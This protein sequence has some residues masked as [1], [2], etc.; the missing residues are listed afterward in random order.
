[1]KKFI[2]KNNPGF[3]FDKK[4]AQEYGERLESVKDIYGSLTADVVLQ[5]AEKDDSPYHNEFI[6]DDTEA[7]HRW[8]KHTARN[9]IGCIHV[10]IEDYEPI[11]RNFECVIVEDEKVYEDIET[12]I[13]SDDLREQVVD[14]LKKDIE[15][16]RMKYGAYKHLQ[17][18]FTKVNKLIVEL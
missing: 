15:K 18:L 2:V 14:R 4:K 17:E 12:V 1:M 9:L 3:Y 6:W 8:R 7:A 16:L 10:E 5:D 11:V 13:G